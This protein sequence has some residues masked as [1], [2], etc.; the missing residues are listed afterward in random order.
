MSWMYQSNDAEKKQ[1]LELVDRGPCDGFIAEVVRITKPLNLDGLKLGEL[2][3]SMVSVDNAA[4]ARKLVVCSIPAERLA[5]GPK[6]IVTVLFFPLTFIARL[7][8]W[9]LS[10]LGRGCKRFFDAVVSQ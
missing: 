2:L 6:G 4:R 10:W 5:Q 7:C 3:L 9:F 1:L 8:W